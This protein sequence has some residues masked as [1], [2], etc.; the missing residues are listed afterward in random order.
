MNTPT[1]QVGTLGL[2]LWESM[3]PTFPALTPLGMLEA[4]LKCLVT[5]SL[6]LILHGNLGFECRLGPRPE[7]EHSCCC[8]SPGHG[9]Q[10]RG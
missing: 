6:A 4:C 3:A 2:V 10:Q 8:S 7:A 9:Q 1:L 5:H